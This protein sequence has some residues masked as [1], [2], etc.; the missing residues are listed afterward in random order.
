MP[1]RRGR[2]ST[3]CACWAAKSSGDTPA[4]WASPSLIHGRKSA[5]AR[6]GNE[7][8]Q[9]GEVAL[10]VD[11]QARHAGAE[12]LLDEHD[13][14]AGLAR[15]GHAH[16]HAVR[17]EV[18]A[19]AGVTPSAVRWWVRR[20]DDR[21]EVQV[22]HAADCR[23]RRPPG[24]RARRS[25]RRETAAMSV[26]RLPARGHQLLR[27]ARG[28]Q[29]PQPT[30]TAN[31]ATYDACV[32][33]PMEAL[34]AD[35]RPASSSRCRLFRPEPRRAVQQGQEP[36][37]DRRSARVGEGEGGTMYYVQLSSKGLLAASGYYH[38]AT[39]QLARFREAVDD[40]HTG[41]EVEGLVPRDG[42]RTGYDARRDGRAQ[43]GAARL[44]EGPPT[45]R[46][47]AAQ[48]PHRAH[49]TGP[50]SAGCT[51]PRPRTRVE[52]TWAG[53]DG[54]NAW[55]DTHVGPSELAPDERDLR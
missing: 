15:P 26:Q 28:R 44:P 12:R 48:G 1:S 8:A 39:D 10:R 18:A 25:T 40:E 11:E 27:G 4:F 5:G 21:A 14:E 36:V 3:A 37:Q 19:S 24:V 20:V 38:M 23:A 42:R 51:R 7:Q 33:G 52:A 49:G 50:C 30:G 55:L 9:V 2:P 46:A 53:C 13:A 32:Q 43:D 17:G 22:S 31:K 6:S 29:L 47:A 45:D 35:G 41:R 34:I 54:L 16:D